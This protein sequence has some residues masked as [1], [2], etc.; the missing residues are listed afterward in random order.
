MW[1]G[2]AP[3]GRGLGFQ[4]VKRGPGSRSEVLL[5]SPSG[6]GGKGSLLPVELLVEKEDQEVDVYFSSVK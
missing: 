6:A 3:L 1:Q 5:P 4:R 2:E